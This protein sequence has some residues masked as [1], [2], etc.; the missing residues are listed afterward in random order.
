MS[1]FAIRALF[2]SIVLVMLLGI[3]SEARTWSSFVGDS[4]F[5]SYYTAACLVRSHL[6]SYVYEEAGQNIDPIQKKADPNT[7]FARTA[8]VRGIPTVALYDYPPTLA[9][10]L[11]PFTFLSPST[12]LV[13]WL[14]INAAALLA[15]GVMLIR[16]TGVEFS[17][18]ARFV[19]LLLFIFRPTLDCF[20]YGQISIILLFLLV[21]GLSL[22]AQGKKTSA[23]L[24]FALAAAIKLTPLIML[25]PLL[26]WRDW[27]TLRAFAMWCAAILGAMLVINGP[28]AL[29]M[30]FLH[31]LPAISSGAVDKLNKS[32]A[33]AVQVFWSGSDAS[34]PLPGVVWAGRLFS[35]A[36]L[37]YA[38]W[39]SRLKNGEKLMDRQRLRMVAVFLLLSCC[40]SPVSWVHAYVLSI[41]AL[42]I[43]GLRIWRG[44]SNAFEAALGVW[45]VVSLTSDKL[46][47][48][49][50]TTGQPIFYYLEV[51]TPIIG[52]ILGILELSRLRHE[53]N[54]ERRDGIEAAAIRPQFETAQ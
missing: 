10:L 36:V 46:F 42:M 20:F 2:L 19:L 3:H 8:R 49:A 34:V 18:V 28:G 50:A 31:E 33:T 41:P 40:L 44:R 12:A 23:A 35:F 4:D 6:N 29:G 37:V 11:K 48:W 9:D 52:L 15:T 39:L 53:R 13:G 5:T 17:G 24:L 21:A 45:F 1:R 7:L 16:M 27:K 38:G 47:G 25:I 32:L 54:L 30:Y 26:A 51:M 14:L 22:Y 43:L